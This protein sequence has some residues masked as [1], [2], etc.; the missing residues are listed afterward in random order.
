MVE[1]QVTF[2][3]ERQTIVEEGVARTMKKYLASPLPTIT[4]GKLLRP[5]AQVT[6][7]ARTKPF[8]VVEFY[9]TGLGI[10][11]Y[12]TITDRLDL[13]TRQVVASP[14]D[15]SYV[16]LF[17]KVNA[18]CKD[19]CRELPEEYLSTLEDIAGLIEVQWGGKSGVLLNDGW[20]NIFY[21]EDVNGEI[22]AV[23]VRWDSDDREWYVGVWELDGVNRC[24]PAVR[25]VLCPGNIAP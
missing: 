20:A 24:W 1:N 17:I 14:P 9:Q 7:P 15:R 6:I 19:I 3:Q 21:V 10:Y 16:A 11:V 22:F 2:G 25:R 5:V 12:G 8:S 18:Y 13:N 23:F 4:E